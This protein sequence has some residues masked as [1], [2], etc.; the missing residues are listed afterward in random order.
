MTQFTDLGLIEPLLRALSHEGY[1]RPTPIQAEAIP[2]ALAGHDLVGAAQTGTGKTAAFALPLIQKL[3]ERPVAPR[4]RTI[5]A[6][7][8]AP[9]RELASQIEDAIRAY[10]RHV[11]VTSATAFGGV[12]IGAQRRAILNGLDILVATPGRLLDLVGSRDLDLSRVEFLVLDE[13]DRMLD[14]GFIHDLRRIANLLPAGRQSLFFSATMPPPIRELAA[15]FLKKTPVEVAVT[16]VASAAETVDQSVVMVRADRK[17]ALLAKVIGETGNGRVLVFTRTKHGADRVV[18]QLA[19]A[20]IDSAAIHGNKSQNQRERALD[21]FRDGSIRVLIAT[22]IA[23]RGIDVEGV[24]L[25]VNY[26]LPNIAET[27]VHRIGRTGRAGAEGRAVAFCIGEEVSYLRDIERLM[28]RRIFELP[29]P[30]GLQVAAALSRVA[31]E[32]PRA[33]GR[34]RDGRGRDGRGSD[35]RG[36]DV[37]SH[38]GRGAGRPARGDAGPADGG[39]SRDVTRP[40]ASDTRPARAEPRPAQKS[41]RR[42]DDNRDE[43]K[44]ERARSEHRHHAERTERPLGQH[45]PATRRRADQ[46]VGFGELVERIS[47]GMNG[48][49][50]GRGEQ[51]RQG[52]R[53]GL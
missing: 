22:D 5:R 16:R 15:R 13:A 10:A 18:K 36:K 52:R 40:A 14:L 44:T 21:G 25:V 23:A 30:E 48:R 1:E 34:G 27:Y 31:V 51:A 37:R 38:E 43:T 46:P 35:P 26:D 8:L 9:T 49:D 42:P 6:L 12:S 4:A 45:P 32:T 53:P 28:R 7:I 50:Q 24:E 11:K 20:G 41:G 29:E 39:R 47:E 17:P 3:I 2:H 19:G 33:D